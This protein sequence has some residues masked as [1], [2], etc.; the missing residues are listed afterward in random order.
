MNKSLGITSVLFIIF[1]FT[2]AFFAEESIVSTESGLK[3]MDL[4]IGTGPIAEVG[5]I[6]VIHFIAW[7]DNNGAKGQEF[8]NSRNRGGPVAFKL[9]TGNVM[10][11]WDIGVAGMKVGGK[12][13]LMVPSELAYGADRVGEVILPNSDLIFEIELLEVK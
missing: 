10:P 4:E 7:L 6:A 2:S 9:G 1:F 8:Y 3:Y 13:R 5:R 12:R 11:G